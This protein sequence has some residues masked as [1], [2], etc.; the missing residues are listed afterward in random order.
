MTAS[1]LG[2]RLALASDRNRYTWSSQ[3]VGTSM[4]VGLVQVFRRRF[5]FSVQYLGYIA[6][7]LNFVASFTSTNVELCKLVTTGELWG[8]AAMSLYY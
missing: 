4:S 5:L 7:D 6:Q 2:C 3:K 1:V 8:K